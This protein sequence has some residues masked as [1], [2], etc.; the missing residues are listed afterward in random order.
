VPAHAQLCSAEFPVRL[1]V[2]AFHPRLTQLIV[3]RPGGGSASPLHLGGRNFTCTTLKLSKIG[4]LPPFFVLVLFLGRA[5]SEERVAVPFQTAPRRVRPQIVPWLKCSLDFPGERVGH[6]GRARQTDRREWRGAPMLESH[7]PLARR[8]HPQRKEPEARREQVLLCLGLAKRSVWWRP[9]GRPA[10]IQRL[11]PQ[12]P[13]SP[14][15]PT[16]PLGGQCGTLR[17]GG[18]VLRLGGIQRVRCGGRV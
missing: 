5:I 10:P 2:T 6:A 9:V 3:S 13:A 11:L 14:S 18:C 17:G 4:S 15:A 7:D 8:C 12:R 1:R 16:S